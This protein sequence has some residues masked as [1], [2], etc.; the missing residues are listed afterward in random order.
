MSETSYRLQ[1]LN[2][3]TYTIANI[4]KPVP[5]K[6]ATLVTSRQVYTYLAARIY[7]RTLIN[8]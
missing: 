4:E 8:I 5:R 7:S 2:S 6:A 3:L 1:V